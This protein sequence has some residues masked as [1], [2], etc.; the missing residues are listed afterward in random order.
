V[1]PGDGAEE[2]GALVAAA[3]HH[4]ARRQEHLKGEAGV[5]EEAAPGVGERGGWGLGC[6]IGGRNAGMLC[7]WGTG[8]SRP[9]TRAAAYLCEEVS[10]P[11]PLMRPPTVRS[12][13]SGRTGSVQPM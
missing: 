4:L 9:T 2:V 6:L 5:L 11:T 1:A 12:S 13:S 3:R 10:M 8:C 7:C